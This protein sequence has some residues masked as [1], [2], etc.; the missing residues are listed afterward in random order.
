MR[1]HGA[2]LKEP[3]DACW[4]DPWLARRGTNMSPRGRKASVERRRRDKVSMLLK[5][6]RACG[7][8]V[9]RPISSITNL[10]IIGIEE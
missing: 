8:S 4:R 9:N 6:Q 5:V 7:P 10:L 1:R 3:T 2:A